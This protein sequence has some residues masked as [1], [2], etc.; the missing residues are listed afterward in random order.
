[1][2]SG[3]V[4]QDA[5]AIKKDYTIDVYRLLDNLKEQVEN[6]RAVGTITF[7]L[8]KNDLTFQ[9]EKIKASLPREV[10]D[11]AS[12]AREHDRILEVAHQ[13]AELLTDQAKR[14]AER[15]VSE[16]KAE[17][18]RVIEQARLKAESMIN[19]SEVLKIAKAQ[20]D[21]IRMAAERESRSLRRGADEY[22]H[23][24]LTH[25]ENVIGKVATQVEKGKNELELNE[26]EASAA[27]ERAKV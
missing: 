13:E 9:I 12:V 15:M 21:E 19:E 10:K 1:M 6:L 7:G 25:L 3:E 14:E 20:S 11:A 4:P 26:R 16:A 2:G 24:V 5:M 22:A 8:N 17:S 27:R 18:D 23:G